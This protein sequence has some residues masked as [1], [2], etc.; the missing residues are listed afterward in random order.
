MAAAAA[1]QST[2][3]KHII[4]QTLLSAA[5]V[6]IHPHR[7]KDINTLNII[8]YG[9]FRSYNLR[10]HTFVYGILPNHRENY[11]ADVVNEKQNSV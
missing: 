9:W 10:H 11:Y 6:F 5:C 2:V 3:I 8:A 1:S 4:V 7:N